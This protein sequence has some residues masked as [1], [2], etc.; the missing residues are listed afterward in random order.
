MADISKLI[1]LNKL[2]ESK[3]ETIELHLTTDFA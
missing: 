1:S 2:G 3:F